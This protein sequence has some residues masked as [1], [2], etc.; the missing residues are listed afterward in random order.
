MSLYQDGVM[1]IIAEY[2]ILQILVYRGPNLHLNLMQ[3]LL[4][5]Q[6]HLMVNIKLLRAQVDFLHQAI[7]E[8]IGM[9]NI[10]TR[11]FLVLRYQ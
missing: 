9:K 5:I 2:I 6:C 10:I 11:I 8:K 3:D 1:L 4:T 7:T